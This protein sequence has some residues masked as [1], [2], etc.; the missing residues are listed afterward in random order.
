[1]ATVN[2]DNLKPKRRVVRS[3]P[4]SLTNT[5]IL[6]IIMLLIGLIVVVALKG[7]GDGCKPSA[8]PVQIIQNLG[9]CGGSQPA[10]ATAT[11][12]VTLPPGAKV[13][14]VPEPGT[15]TL[16]GVGAVALLSR[17]ITRLA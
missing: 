14:T 6:L 16:F 13:N 1:M 11:C 17:R 3:S 10:S 15:M 9:C 4:W 8:T 2:P 5:L 12:K 7:G